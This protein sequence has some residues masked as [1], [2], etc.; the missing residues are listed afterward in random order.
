[1]IV[2]F[3]ISAS[4]F[5]FTA[6]FAL[7]F[8]ACGTVQSPSPSRNASVPTASDSALAS[9]WSGA[10]A[11]DSILARLTLEEKV[12]QMI[13]LRVPGYYLSTDGDIFD[14]LARRVTVK[15]IGGVILTQGDVYESAITL[16]ALQRLAPL[17][18][19]VA[20]DFEKGIAMRTRRGTSFPDAMALGATRKADLA[21]RMGKAI[22]REG[23]AI[24]V[25]QNFAPVADINTNPL[26]PAINTRAFTDDPALDSAMVSAFVRGAIEGG[27][28]PTAKHFPGHGDTGDDSHLTL[29]VLSLSKARLDSMEFKSFR[30]SIDA[31]VPSVM[32][33]HLMVP[34]L[35]SLNRPASLSPIVIQSLLRGSLKFSGL[36]VTDALEMQGVSRGGR[37][38]DVALLAVKAGVDM[39]LVPPDEDDAIGAIVDAVKRGEIPLSRIDESVRRVLMAKRDVGLDRVRLVDPSNIASVVASRKHLALAREIGRGGITVLKNAG[40][41]LPLPLNNGKRIAVVLASDV[42]ESRQEIDRP[43]PSSTTESFGTYFAQNMRRRSPGVDVVRIDPTSS[44]EELESARNAV[45]KANIA[46]IALFVKVRTATGTVGPPEYLTQF[47]ASLASMKTPLCVCTF[48]SP[49]AVTSV[50]NARAILCAYGDTESQE[51]AAAEALFGEIPVQ[52]RLPVKI[53]PAYAFGSGIDLPQTR[54]RR[55]D[56]WLAGVDPERLQGVE[57]MIQQAIADSAFP[58]AQ[59]AVV[60][61]GML[62]EQKSFGRQTYDSTAA[63]IDAGT[64][65]DLASLT[66]VVSTTSAM[67]RL[68]DL[69]KFSLDDSVAKYLPA[70]GA[71]GKER[72][73]I[74][75]L[76]THRGGLPPFRN[77]WTFCRDSAAAVDSIFATPIMLRPGDST[78]YSDL[79]MITVGKLVERLSG[80]TLDQFVQKEF[81]GPL[82][83]TSTM[84]RPPEELRAHCAPTE[85]DSVWRK[86]LVQGTVHDEN[87]AFLGGVSGHAGLFSTANDLAVFAQ[88]LLN[89]GTYGGKRYISEGT[90]YEFLGRKTAR[91]ERWLGWDMRAASGS[92]SGNHFSKSSFGHTGFTGTSIWVDPERALAVILLTNRV[93]PTREGRGFNGFRPR[94]HDAIIHALEDSREN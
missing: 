55:E 73:T 28:M 56:P 94:L 74:R 93:Y 2:R 14:R 75:Q 9:G 43:G 23:R 42:E 21:F 31:G 19:L 63:P 44:K 92:S 81:F 1:M 13:M 3:K 25:H 45:R 6:S 48:G 85:V 7:I 69:G 24:G 18:L 86:R 20:A 11:I 83:M 37:A 58:G 27:Q 22:A 30:A 87:A 64:M 39:L 16:N 65:F 60:K 67:M 71:G 35:D 59:L 82:R 66:K 50:P 84:Y 52:G 4:S 62:I 90:M 51:A 40:D 34:S 76:L 32:I 53:V 79:G 78:L 77:F 61:G 68:Y 72:V 89:K 5:L 26:N 29:P 33:G 91:Q 15:K 80:M 17:P 46:V 12:G 38:G 54:L 88:M 49:Y 36:V 8:S 57:E 47:T 10:R 70:F 41:L